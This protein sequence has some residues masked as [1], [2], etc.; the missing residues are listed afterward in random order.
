MQNVSYYNRIRSPFEVIEADADCDDWIE[1]FIKNKNQQQ[2][3]SFDSFSN[4]QLLTNEDQYLIKSQQ[5]EFKDYSLISDEKYHFDIDSNVLSNKE[6][7]EKF[8]SEQYCSNYEDYSN[9]ASQMCLEISTQLSD[10]SRIQT[11]INQIPTLSIVPKSS[12]NKVLKV[13]RSKKIPKIK[14][15]KKNKFTRESER[16]KNIVK[17]YGKKCANFAI[18]KIGQSILREKFTHEEYSQFKEYIKL[19]VCKITNIQNF[20]DMLLVLESDSVKI[21][22]FKESFQ[23]VS[24]IFIRNYAICWIFHSSRMNDVKG[25]VFARHKMLRRI[26]DPKSFTY[27]H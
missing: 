26:Q 22:K 19:R 7:L 3:S 24:E 20:R 21:A 11:R 2:S 17:N 13:T 9:S 15:S 25:H 1:S 8:Q 5:E 12:E 23:F 14:K 27:I 6:E 10:S 4:L 18:G 16:L